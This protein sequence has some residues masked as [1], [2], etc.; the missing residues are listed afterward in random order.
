M[1]QLK[2]GFIDFLNLAGGSNYIT[3]KPDNDTWNSNI[4]ITDRRVLW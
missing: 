1:D 3:F 4:T 2:S